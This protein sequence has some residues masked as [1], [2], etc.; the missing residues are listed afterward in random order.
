MTDF[1]G[2]LAA[3]SAAAS[4]VATALAA[5]ASWRGP[6]A[7]AEM[8][9]KL[10]RD[11]E[12]DNERKRQ[13][14]WVFATLMQERSAIY[15]ETAVRA[16]NTIDAVFHDVRRVREAWAELYLKVNSQNMQASGCADELR[17]LLAAMAS[18]IGLADEFGHADAA[19]IY[20]PNALAQ[21]RLVRD[22]ERQQALARLQGSSPTANAT[23]QVV[24]LF[25]P[26]P[27]K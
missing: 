17:R 23:S 13:K 27:E 6:R 8:A 14:F 21:E 5:Y 9:E 12:A 18:D 3:F 25:P 4:A 7:A 19:R 22:L 2:P 16:L 11:A 10:R 20:I 15:T 24:A 26:K 1:V